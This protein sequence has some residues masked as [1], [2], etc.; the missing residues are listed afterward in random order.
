VD[1]LPLLRISNGPLQEAE[2]GSPSQDCGAHPPNLR[3][4]VR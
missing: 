1:Y 2:N 4:K 3:L